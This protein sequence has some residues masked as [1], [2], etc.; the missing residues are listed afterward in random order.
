MP[1]Q[2]IWS[3]LSESDLTSIINYLHNNWEDNVVLRFIEITDK[4][5]IQISNH[6]KQFPLIHKKEKVRKCVLTKHNTIYYRERKDY[7]DI[8]RIFDTRQDPKKLSF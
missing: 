7:I 1:K 5:L 8:L 2:I 4:I 3:P 6:P